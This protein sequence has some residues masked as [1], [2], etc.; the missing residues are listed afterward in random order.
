MTDETGADAMQELAD[1][2]QNLN[3]ATLAKVNLLEQIRQDG[4][5]RELWGEFNRA[6]D[7]EYSRAEA[8][9]EW[10]QEHE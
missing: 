4:P 10:R 6:I 5:T 1:I 2:I 7:R 9:R 8:L 3:S